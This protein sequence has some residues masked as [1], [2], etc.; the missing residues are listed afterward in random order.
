MTSRPLN[1]YHNTAFGRLNVSFDIWT[2]ENRGRIRKWDR[3][4]ERCLKQRHHRTN[5]SVI[6]SC[7]AASFCFSPIFAKRVVFS[8]RMERLQRWNGTEPGKPLLGA[9]GSVL[10]RSVSAVHSSCSHMSKQSE[11]KGKWLLPI[12]PLMNRGAKAPRRG[13]KKL[14][15]SLAVKQQ[16]ILFLFLFYTLFRK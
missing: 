9:L 2:E 5:L 10:F 8:L 7:Q 14:S 3:R 15:E 11:P 13:N 4:Q 12:K 1:Y 16:H 6:F